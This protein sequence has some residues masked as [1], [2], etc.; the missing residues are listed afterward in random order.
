MREDI[1]SV[2]INPVKSFHSF[3]ARHAFQ[4]F[5]VVS[6]D[7]Q[8]EFALLTSYRIRQPIKKKFID[9]IRN[10]NFFNTPKWYRLD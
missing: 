2:A 5:F 4:K 7:N 3:I 9:L 10:S 1:Q 6:N 8:L